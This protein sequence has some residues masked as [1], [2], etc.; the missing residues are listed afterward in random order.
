MTYR[1]HE[2]IM[3]GTS[4]IMAQYCVFASSW[5]RVPQ[6][7]GDFCIAIR[8]KYMFV[9]W[10]SEHPNRPQTSVM[11][12][13][14]GLSAPPLGNASI[15]QGLSKTYFNH[16]SGRPKGFHAS[17]DPGGFLAQQFRRVWLL[18]LRVDRTDAAGNSTHALTASALGVAIHARPSNNTQ[19]RTP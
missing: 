9:A 11:R 13:V 3:S 10:G 15:R 12:L 18:L 1:R 17:S 5:H 2:T 19:H 14:E 4:R 16:V 7:C 6:P 8:D